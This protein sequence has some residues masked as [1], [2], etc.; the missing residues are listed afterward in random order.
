M[1][2]SW[3]ECPSVLKRGRRRRRC[4]LS[5]STRGSRSHCN[6]VCI[7]PPT[8]SPRSDFSM[9]RSLQISQSDWHDRHG[10]S[11]ED[12]NGRKT[13][14]RDSHNE[15]VCSLLPSC[16]SSWQHCWGHYSFYESM[17]NGER[18]SWPQNSYSFEMDLP[19]SNILC[20]TL[21]II[22]VAQHVCADVFPSGANKKRKRNG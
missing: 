22:S 14:A 10:Q 20:H 17:M 2:T 3:N 21:A 13:V 9:D 16:L 1:W 15:R 5:P 6:Y 11:G 12:Y 18:E 7:F 19:A 4:F 8:S